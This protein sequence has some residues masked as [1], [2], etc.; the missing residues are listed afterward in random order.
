MMWMIMK[1][2]VPKH[3]KRWIFEAQTPDY[4]GMYEVDFAVNPYDTA[5]AMEDPDTLQLDLVISLDA[6]FQCG[7]FFCSGFR[8]IA[9]AYMYLVVYGE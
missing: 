6:D 5:T 4:S 3:Y 2:N 1:L 7:V 9:H 8:A